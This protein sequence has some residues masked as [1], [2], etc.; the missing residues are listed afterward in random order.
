MLISC[1]YHFTPSTF[2]GENVTLSVPYIQGDPKAQ[3]NNEIVRAFTSSGRFTCVQS[4]GDFFLQVQLLSDTNDRIGYRYDRDTSSGRRLP[5]ILAV[6]NRRKVVANVTL[7][8]SHSGDVV[9]GPLPITA[10]SDYDYADPGSPRDLDTVTTSGPF[11]TIRYSYGQLNTIEGAHDDAGP[12]LYAHLSQKIM[13]CI[14]NQLF[15]DN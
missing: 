7:Y 9:F 5:N 13:Q 14:L 4:G 15:L 2:E 10:T 6:E 8:D 1:G 11:P 3:L 12:N